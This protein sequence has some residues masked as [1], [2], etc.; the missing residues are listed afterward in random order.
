M[1]VGVHTPPYLYMSMARLATDDI[2]HSGWINNTTN[3]ILHRYIEEEREDKRE[4]VREG[5]NDSEV[6]GREQIKDRGQQRGR[7]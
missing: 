5:K 1:L 3:S 2:M 4:E 6:R 7:E